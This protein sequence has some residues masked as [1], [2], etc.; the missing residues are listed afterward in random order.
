M[1]NLTNI[2]KTVGVNKMV[3]TVSVP[4]PLGNPQLRPDDEW[5]L[6]YH[7]TGVALDALE[8]DV[9]GQTIFPVKI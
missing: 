6:L 8:T 1:C 2:A 4:Y 3:P 9:D 7:R 5:A